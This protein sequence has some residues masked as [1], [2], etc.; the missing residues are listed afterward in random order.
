MICIDYVINLNGFTL[1]N[2]TDAL[3]LQSTATLKYTAL[4][5]SHVTN[6]STLI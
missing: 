5:K 2:N 3:S 4:G 1:I 6:I